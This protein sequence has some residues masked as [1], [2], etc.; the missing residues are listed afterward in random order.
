MSRQKSSPRFRFAGTAALLVLLSLLIPSLREGDPRL[1]LLTAGVTGAMLLCMIIPARLF[2]LDRL[3]LSIALYLCA[4][5]II[6]I[7]P[8]DPDAALMQLLRCGAGVVALIIG[9]MMV[10]VL[11]SSALTA[12]ISS[13]LGLLLLSGNLLARDPALPFTQAALLLLI[14]ASASLLS[15]RGGIAAFL[16]ALIGTAMLLLQGMTVEAIILAL[17]AVLLLWSADG[18]TI[19]SLAALLACAALF[20]GSRQLGHLPVPALAEEHAA[21]LSSLAAAGLTGSENIAAALDP[22]LP[23]SSLLYR[24]SDS[25]GL[26]FT[27]LT[28]LLFL[29]LVLRCTSV[30]CT[31]RSR[32]YAVLAMGCTLIFALPVPAFL[33]SAFGVLPLPLKALPLLTDSLPDLCAQMLAL[34]ML[35]GISSVNEADLAEDAHLA[36]LAR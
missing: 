4:V 34:G 16:P 17:T 35:C 13:F 5:G 7:A 10:R 19:V 31:A 18:R 23:A 9:A 28:L 21:S 20:L 30:A 22:V 32:F 14:I 8:A 36:M 25:F 3:I 33:L 27:A 24:L 6:S 2:S 12:I 11:A 15:S 26:I 1:Y 29:P